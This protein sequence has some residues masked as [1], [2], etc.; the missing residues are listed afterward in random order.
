M[1]SM[2]WQLGILGTISGFAFRYRE[3]KSY[4]VKSYLTWSVA[5]YNK[6]K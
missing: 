6:V 1:R 2:K 4:Q 3:V 5:K